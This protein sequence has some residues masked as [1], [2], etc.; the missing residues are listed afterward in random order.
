MQEYF[1]ESR[2]RISFDKTKESRLLRTVVLQRREKSR[3]HDR[4]E[5]GKA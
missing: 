4:K 3:Q 5:T 1:A 2:T